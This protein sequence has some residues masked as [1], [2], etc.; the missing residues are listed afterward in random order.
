MELWDAYDEDFNKI[1]GL[2]LIR[3]ERIPK[4]LFHL[5]CDIIVKHIDGTYLLMQRDRSKPHGGMW[6]A[7]AGGSALKNETPFECAIRG[8]REETGIDSR[9]L[10]EVGRVT[11]SNTIFVEFLCVTDCAKDS[12]TL[13]DGETIAYK[14]IIRDELVTMSKNELITD[15]MQAFIEELHV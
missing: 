1:E 8:L 3:G 15:R 7:S 12:I 2:T 14:W 6:E 11:T 10:I 5:A 13:Q 4:G 9:D